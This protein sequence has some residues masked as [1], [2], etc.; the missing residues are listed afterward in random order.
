MLLLPFLTVLIIAVWLGLLV[1]EPIAA[2]PV[3]WL[4]RMFPPSGAEF[5]APVDRPLTAQLARLV[6]DGRAWVDDQQVVHVTRG[7]PLGKPLICPPC[8]AWW[9]AVLGAVAALA[10]GAQWPVLLAAPGSF[11]LASMVVR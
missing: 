5:D 9:L 8:A 10:L 2:G 1:L 4:G 3:D 11:V 7:T 6:H